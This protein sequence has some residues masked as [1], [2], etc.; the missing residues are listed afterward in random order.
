MWIPRALFVDMWVS[1]MWIC[2]VGMLL[3][4]M[5]M[6]LFVDV[7]GSLCGCVGLSL[8][9]R[10]AV[11]VHMYGSL[12]GCVWLSLWIRRALFVDM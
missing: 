9:I 2:R 7:Y 11:F 5:C 3:L 12:C 6:A 10:R 8:C 1:F 4:C